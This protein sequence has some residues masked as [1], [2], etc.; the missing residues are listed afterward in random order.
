V[1]LGGIIQDTFRT[2]DTGFGYNAIEYIEAPWGQNQPLYPVQKFLLKCMYSLPLDERNKTIQLGGDFNQEV[3]REFTERDFLQFLYD[4]GRINISEVDPDRVVKEACWV[5]G[6]RGTKTSLAAWI[7]SFELAKLLAIRDPAE[8]YGLKKGQRVT[9]TNLATGKDQ[10]Q[11]LFGDVSFAITNCSLFTPHVEDTFKTFISVWSRKQLEERGKI[12]R[13]AVQMVC[14]PCSARSLRGPA[15][16]MVI[17]DEF[18]HF[19][20]EL[21]GSNK[22]DQSVYNSATPSVADFVDPETGRPDG[23]ILEIST[24]LNKDGKCWEIHRKGIEEKDQNVLVVRMP[25]WWVNPRLPTEF[26]RSRYEADPVVY[27]CEFESE[28][29]DEIHGYLEERELKPNVVPGKEK[30]A[31]AFIDRR[32]ERFMGIDLGLKGDGS[33]WTI[34][35][36]DGSRYV[37][38]HHE[39]HYAGKG[40]WKDHEVLPIEQIA[41]MIAEDAES[42][43]V[44]SGVFDQY[45]SYGLESYLNTYGVNYLAQVD[46]TRKR[47]SDV[48]KLGKQLIRASSLELIDDEECYKELLRLKERVVSENMIIVGAPP[49]KGAHDDYS[50]SLFR[51]VFVAFMHYRNKEAPTEQDIRQATN[52]QPAQGYAHLRKQVLTGRNMRS[53]RDL[54]VR[55]GGLLY[56]LRRLR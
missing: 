41:A 21:A 23:K 39:I 32:T 34:I 12:G 49:V 5:I 29:S 14:A 50:D 26:L 52:A 28:F 54:G 27:G 2:E 43:G 38:D 15:N 10:A 20:V 19:M 33:A 55:P 48:Y 51:A 17:F 37:E 8:Y 25:S 7:T 40:D 11:E 47:N 53:V 30:T 22:S 18:A 6:R 56:H 9:F 31:V 42:F 1:A 3:V 24:P 35:H 36:R 16:K 46:F 13:S 45:N 4:E 44:V